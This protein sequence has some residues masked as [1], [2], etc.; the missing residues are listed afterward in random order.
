MKIIVPNL[1]RRPD[2]KK[3]MLEHFEK[4]DVPM[5]DVRFVNSHDAENYAN[6]E[7]LLD[8]MR[9]SGWNVPGDTSTLLKGK[10][11]GEKDQKKIPIRNM[12]HMAFRWTYLDILREIEGDE[13]GEQALI[14]VDDMFLPYT[15]FD[16]SRQIQV[17]HWNNC[18]AL[19]LDPIVETKSNH[20]RRGYHAPTEEAIFWTPMGAQIAIP[21]LLQHPAKVI[22]DILRH[23]FPEN[24]IATTAKI[25]A[26]S[27]G[28]KADWNSDIHINS[29]SVFRG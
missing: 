25:M 29:E 18:Y 20:Q 16:Y 8:A 23:H 13:I 14:L 17:M 24:Q 2:K 11:L 27:I 6:L 9:C 19:A 15:P 4:Y 3:A 1:H 7:C 28:N 12:P 21:L 22:G 10:L 26:K 5:E